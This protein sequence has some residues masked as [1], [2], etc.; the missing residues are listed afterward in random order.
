MWAPCCAP[1]QK[2]PP[3]TTRASS[4]PLA[5][6][7]AISRAREVVASGETPKPPGPARNSPDSLSS[8]RRK[9]LLAYCDAGEAADLDVLAQG[10]GGLLDELAD[11]P[12]V[13]LDVGLVEQ[14]DLGEELVQTALDDLVGDGLGVALLER[15]L[16]ERRALGGD[17]VL[18]HALAAHAR[19]VRYRY[20]HGQVLGQLAE[21]VGAGHQ[22]G[23]AVDLH[24]RGELAV[25]G[26]VRAHDA[27]RGLASRLLV[28]LGDAA[29]AQQL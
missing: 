11:G 1:R 26:D 12:L 6:A 21:G 5:L 18:G 28:G 25:V 4:T 2:F 19:R 13:V 16:A 23:L 14:D 3:P 10:G 17:D 9:A 24:E 27:L 29:L 15:L 22:V 8:A 7:A 20:V